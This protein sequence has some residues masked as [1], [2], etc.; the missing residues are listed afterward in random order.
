IGGAGVDEGSA[1]ASGYVTINNTANISLTAKTQ[2]Q[3][4]NNGLLSGISLGR[5]GDLTNDNNNSNGGA[6]GLAQAV[7]ITNTGELTIDG[8]VPSNGG[9]FG[10]NVLAQGGGGGDQND[11]AL[12]YGDQVGGDGANASTVTIIDSGIVNMGSSDTRLK[13]SGTGMA[14]AARSLGGAGGDYNSN[15]GTGGTV[16]VTH[17]G[18][19]SSYWQ[20]YENSKIFGIKAE[21]LGADGN[22]A[23]PNNPDNSDNGGDGGG[24]DDGWTQKVTVDAYGTVLLDLAGSDPDVAVEGAGIAARAVGG[25][26]GMGGAVTVN[27]YSGASVTARGNNLPAIAAQSLGGQ[28]GDADDGTALAGQGGGG[29]FGGAAGTVNVTTQSNSIVSTSGMYSS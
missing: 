26:G 8:T 19:T 2:E 7:S 12:D 21:S 10:I 25:K 18:S 29:G 11:P 28:G 14:L 16:Q 13:T 22:G 27:L 9:L 24:D 17:R 23:N 15:A 1:G 6:G 20:L 3:G 4:S 5:Q